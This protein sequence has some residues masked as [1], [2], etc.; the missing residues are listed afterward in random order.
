MSRVDAV[1]RLSWEEAR[2]EVRQVLDSLRVPTFRESM[3]IAAVLALLAFF[4]MHGPYYPQL[5]IIGNAMNNAIYL[6]TPCPESYMDQPPNCGVQIPYRWILA[7]LV[8][9]VAGCWYLES[10]R[11]K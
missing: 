8:L 7:V 2:Q 11:P 1:K 4:L 6:T 5:G 3:A 9:F 10:K